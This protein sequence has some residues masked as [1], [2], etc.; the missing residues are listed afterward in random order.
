MATTEVVVAFSS[1]GKELH[2]PACGAV[3]ADHS[4]D[5]S[6][7][8]NVVTARQTTVSGHEDDRHALHRL[9]L[10]EERVGRRV[11]GIGEVLDHFTHL[12]HVGTRRG[13]RLLGAHNS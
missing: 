8:L 12:L 1:E 13:D 11:R 4:F 7:Y 6:D 3:L 2:F 10:A 9:D 5:R